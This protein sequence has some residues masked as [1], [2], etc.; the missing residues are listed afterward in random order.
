M[1]PWNGCGGHRHRDDLDHGHQGDPPA[2]TACRTNSR[3]PARRNSVSGSS[4]P[5]GEGRRT[6]VLSFMAYHSSLEMW[7]VSNPRDTPLPTQP[8]PTFDHSSHM[9]RRASHGDSRRAGTAYGVDGCR[10]GWFY[11]ALVSGQKPSWGVVETIAELVAVTNNL[12]RI[13]IDIPIGLPNDERGRLC[14]RQARRELTGL[15]ASSVFP[16]PARS[17]LTAKNYEE[18]NCQN[19]KAAGK[20]LT[21]QTY[22]ILPKIGEVDCLLRCNKKARRTVREVHPEIC[23]WAFAGR[24][25]MRHN[26][27]TGCGFDQRLDLLECFKPY[28]GTSFRK[29]FDE[30]RPQY[31]CSDLADD[32][33]LDAMAAAITASVDPWALKTLPDCPNRDSCDLPMEIVYAPRAAFG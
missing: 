25:P 21:R 17:V 3:A 15:R 10:K 5:S 1:G 30:I 24:S 16:A 13:F 33:I 23:F 18:A 26:K 19:R 2:S 7:K 29:R 12:D 27:K 31:R 11:F 6:T 9:H 22:A 14:D 32:D 28:V 8:S 4:T 20:G